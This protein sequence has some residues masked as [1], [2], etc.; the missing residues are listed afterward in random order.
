MDEKTHI[1]QREAAGSTRSEQPVGGAL[2]LPQD[3]RERL[4]LQLRQAVNG[5]VENPHG[6]V[7]EADNAFDAAATRL[8]ELLA[9]L[10]QSIRTSWRNGTAPEQG[11]ADTEALRLAL[12]RYREHTERLLRL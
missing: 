3:E 12:Q 7:Q 9:E 11:P 6:A 10:R 8:T 4:E 2:L 5:F 1:P